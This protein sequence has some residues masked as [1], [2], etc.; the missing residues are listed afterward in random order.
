M[1]TLMI[2]TSRPHVWVAFIQNGK[3]ISEKKWES[4]KSLGV[5]LL[6]MIGEMTNAGRPDRI[7]VHCGPGHFMAVRTGVVTAQLLAQAW[8]V[9]L[10]GMDG[11]ERSE[12]IRQAGENEAVEVVEIQY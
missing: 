1:T 4:D 9:E 11:Q 3:M 7:A 8:G 5:K 2:D 10:V 6:K 12:V